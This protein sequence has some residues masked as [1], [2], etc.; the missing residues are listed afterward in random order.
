M[1]SLFPVLSMSARSL[2]SKDQPLLSLNWIR[3]PPAASLPLGGAAVGGAHA[4]MP[5]LP[6]LPPPLPAVLPPLPAVLP[7]VPPLPPR[8][9]TPP[10][11]V[12]L[13]PRPP[14]APAVPDVPAV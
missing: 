14:A 11:P 2:S 1:I 5:P 13:P 4:V 7:A 12:V 8:P 10:V 3:L 9:P 6:A